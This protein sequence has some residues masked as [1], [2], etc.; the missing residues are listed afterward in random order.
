MSETIVDLLR[1]GEVAGGH[2]LR[3]RRT[4]QPLSELGWRQLRERAGSGVAWQRIISSP[5]RRCREFAEETARRLE[6]PLEVMDG[7]AELDFGAWDGLPMERLWSEHGEAAMGFLSDPTSHTPPDG[8]PIEDFRERV[9]SAWSG[10]LQR[11]AG[12]HLLVVAHGGV[13]RLILSHILG[14]P[15]AAMF[16]VE[17]PHACL[18]RVRADGNGGRLVY[19]GGEL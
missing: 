2:L 19:H 7:L 6:L 1:H 15:L 16:R 4:D 13:N 14:M 17:V 9:L 5:L 12:E 8:E 10:L 18:S 3:G 11:Y